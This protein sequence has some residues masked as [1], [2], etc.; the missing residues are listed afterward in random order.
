MNVLSGPKH[1]LIITA[2]W[3]VILLGAYLFVVDLNALPTSVF[4]PT[5]HNKLVEAVVLIAGGAMAR[6]PLVDLSVQSIRRVGGFEGDIYV[7]TDHP[8]CFSSTIKMY[9]IRP[10]RVPEADMAT[11]VKI[12]TIKAKLFSY[13]PDSLHHILYMDVDVVVARRLGGFLD[14][15]NEQLVH[16]IKTHPSSAPAIA[17]KESD[18]AVSSTE[19]SHLLL[20]DSS[21][22]H[23]VILDSTTAPD[24]AMFL[25]AGG[26]FAGNLVSGV[27]KWHT[28]VMWI[29]RGSGVRCM[30]V[31]E[32]L[33]LSDKYDSDQQA[34]DVAEG[35]DENACPRA[36]ELSFRHLLFA[37]DYLMMLFRGGQTFIHFTAAGRTEDQNSFY[38]GLA[39]PV[40]RGSIRPKLDTTLL[41]KG[42][43]QCPPPSL[44]A[45][46]AVAR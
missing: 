44:P 43:K 37:K 42:D 15:L 17:E 13:L 45:V 33:L 28:G 14:E 34:L 41:D 7:L 39:M 4:V 16:F 10:I 12:K 30:R 20:S 31:W 23:S 40:L 38:S 3:A 25:D 6:S 27:E 24:Y 22:G 29:R 2:V 1:H 8:E 9:G 18:K 36:M 46:A 26:H 21:S 19:A 5:H 11:I 32:R 35:E